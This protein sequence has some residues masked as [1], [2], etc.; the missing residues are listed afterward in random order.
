[1]SQIVRPRPCP[2]SGR[3]IRSGSCT[4]VR[5]IWKRRLLRTMIPETVE[6]ILL[7]DR[8]FGRTELARTCRQLRFYY[9]IRIKPDVW[10]DC[11]EPPCMRKKLSRLRTVRSGAMCS[12]R[13]HFPSIW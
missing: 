7:A 11:P 3:R 1:M 8:G 10:I 12:S 2:C 6:V 4:R 9:L 5:T 13:R